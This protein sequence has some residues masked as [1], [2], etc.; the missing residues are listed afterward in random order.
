MTQERAPAG[1]FGWRAINS[2]PR[3]DE[4]PALLN[5]YVTRWVFIAIVGLVSAVGLWALNVTIVWKSLWLAV[6][7]DILLVLCAS[8][9]NLVGAQTPRIGR[10]T[11]AVSDLLLSTLQFIVALKVLTPL[12]YLAAASGYPLVDNELTRLDAVL[13]GFSGMLRPIGSPAIRFS[14]GCSSTRIAAYIIKA[15]WYS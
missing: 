14:I 9:Y 7:V 5:D 12:T 6:E 8:A 13:F 15:L 2:D 1:Q 10:S 11:A 4:A 3:P